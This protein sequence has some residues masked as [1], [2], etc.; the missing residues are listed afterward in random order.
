VVV[1]RDRVLHTLDLVVGRLTRTIA[2]GA[3][4]VSA[5]GMPRPAGPGRQSATR[6][7]PKR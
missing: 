4:A 2:R 6:A 5:V 7:R 1:R 3:P